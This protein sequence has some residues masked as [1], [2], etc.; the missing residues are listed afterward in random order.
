MIRRPPRS[1]L[2]PY[3]T[4][5][6]SLGIGGLALAFSSQKT[7]ENLFGG[8]SII[9]DRPMRIGDICKFGDVFGTVKDIGLRSTRIRT[10]DRTIVT[11]PNAQVS[12][13]NLENFTLRDKFWFHPIISLRRETTINR[14]KPFFGISVICWIKTLT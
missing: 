12:T 2:F 9:S 5:F 6:R 10:F 3:T 8:I 4:L 1:T 13:M 11:I 7:L 14:W